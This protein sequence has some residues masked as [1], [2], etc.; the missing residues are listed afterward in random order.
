MPCLDDHFGAAITGPL[1]GPN[2]SVPLSREDVE[3]MWRSAKDTHSCGFSIYT[4][5]VALRSIK[6]VSFASAVESNAWPMISQVFPV[7]NPTSC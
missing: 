7:L 5:A 6:D 4:V 3:S 2:A 1:A